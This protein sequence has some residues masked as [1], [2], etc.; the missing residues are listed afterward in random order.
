MRF[1]FHDTSRDLDPQ[2]HAH[3]VFGNVTWDAERG[4]WFALQPAEMLRE[5]LH[6]PHAPTVGAFFIAATLR[7]TMNPDSK[8]PWLSRSPCSSRREV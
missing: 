6:H 5:W 7:S 1:F 4:D 8:F 2:L 3:A